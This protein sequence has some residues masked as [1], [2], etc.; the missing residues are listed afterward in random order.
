M[1]RFAGCLAKVYN[2]GM[3]TSHE[4]GWE[5]L[6]CIDAVHWLQLQATNYLR[7]GRMRVPLPVT[8]LMTH[9]RIFVTYMYYL[10]QDRQRFLNHPE[11]YS[12]YI[13]DDLAHNRG[14]KIR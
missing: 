12:P 14:T 5:E 7:Y 10:E 1:Y 11:G 6:E 9:P 3:K 2:R 8:A 4:R 13:A